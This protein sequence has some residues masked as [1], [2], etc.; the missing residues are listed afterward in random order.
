MEKYESHQRQ[1]LRPAETVY[2]LVSDFTM[3]TPAI[4]DKVE[5]WQ[6]TPDECSFKAKGFRVG[7]RIIEREQNRTVKIG[8]GEGV[9]VNFTF[10]IQLKEV[11][12]EDTRIRLVLHA[13]IPFA[14]KMMIGSKIQPVIDRM[15][16]S[17]A[18][19]MNR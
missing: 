13:D 1:I 18:E 3:L 11:A 12:P 9:P 19:A 15:V 4:A 6:A 8:G 7:L 14:V 10:W 16:D 5:E 2:R 17:V